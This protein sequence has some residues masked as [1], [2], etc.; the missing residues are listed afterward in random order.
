[1][2]PVHC[3]SGNTMTIVYIRIVTLSK[4]PWQQFDACSVHHAAEQKLFQRFYHKGKILKSQKLTIAVNIHVCVAT[5]LETWL[6]AQC[7]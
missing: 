5:M 6:T 2:L 7:L 1:M 4:C 3:I